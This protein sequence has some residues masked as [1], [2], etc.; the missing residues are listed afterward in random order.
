MFDLNQ[1]LQPKD[2]L[3][4]PTAVVITRMSEKFFG[5]RDPISKKL[6]FNGRE[7]YFVRGVIKTG[8]SIRISI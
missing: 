5:R 7:D 1:L 4:D 8:L 3:S 2:A 6:T